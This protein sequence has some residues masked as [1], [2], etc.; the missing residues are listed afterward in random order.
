MIY[1]T[2]ILLVVIY[3]SSCCSRIDNYLIDIDKIDGVI[4]GQKEYLD[5]I[6]NQCPVDMIFM[7]S[8]FIFRSYCEKYYF[9]IY[10]Y[11]EFT[12]L[13]SFGEQ[14]KGPDEFLEGNITHGHKIDDN[15]IWLVD[16]N[17]RKFKKADVSEGTVKKTILMPK[18]IGAPVNVSVISDNLII[19]KS[20]SEYLGSFF[21]YDIEEDRIIENNNVPRIRFKV[22]EPKKNFIYSNTIRVN[23]YN[24]RIV[25]AY[26]FFGQIDVFDF[27][28]NKAFSIKINHGQKQANWNKVEDYEVPFGAW[29]Y[30]N[31]LQTTDSYI[32]ALYN[33]YQVTE[34]LTIDI[35]YSNTSIILQFNWNG[36]LINKFIIPELI[37]KF[38]VD[39]EFSKIIAI[40]RI[41]TESPFII[42]NLSSK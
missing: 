19:G 25:V 9:H 22:T 33:N 3:L 32:F 24:S 39:S 1:K 13:K 4:I 18:E 41:N 7:D 6:N 29:S 16:L 28:L 26:D 37:D 20:L 27:N 5:I 30:F 34:D 17:N 14:G 31:D 10:E 21:I 15:S 40:R 12:H 35:K 36:E 11:P 8:L 23:E 2:K 42:Y 38:L